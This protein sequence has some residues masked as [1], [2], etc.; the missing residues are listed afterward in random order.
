M[1]IIFIVQREMLVLDQTRMSLGLSPQHQHLKRMAPPHPL[2]LVGVALLPTLG[3]VWYAAL[4]KTGM[5]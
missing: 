1:T 2:M 5:N 3:G 4:W